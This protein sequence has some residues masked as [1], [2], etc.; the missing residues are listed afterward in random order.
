MVSGGSRFLGRAGAQVSSSGENE[1]WRPYKVPNILVP[2]R[3]FAN[4]DKEQLELAV[5]ELAMKGE[6]VPP[7]G[8]EQADIMNMSEFQLRD[9]LRQAGDEVSRA[10]L[11]QDQ[12]SKNWF[13]GVLS[14][15]GGAIAGP[16]MKVLDPIAAFGEIGASAVMGTVQGFIPGEQEYE[17]LR[18][19][20]MEARGLNGSLLDWITDPLDSIAAQREAW[21]EMEAPW[22]TKFAMEVIFDPLNLVPFKWITAPLKIGARGAKF[23]ARGMRPVEMSIARQQGMKHASQIADKQFKGTKS[24]D[25]LDG[26]VRR[27]RD[28]AAAR[29]QLL[30]P[31]I[32]IGDRTKRGN[33]LEQAK[34]LELSISEIRKEM[35]DRPFG[36][37]SFRYAANEIRAGRMPNPPT[38]WKPGFFD[39]GKEP[40]WRVPKS[41]AEM[42]ARKIPVYGPKRG[43]PGPGEVAG[44]GGAVPFSPGQLST[45]PLPPVAGG[46]VGEEGAAHRVIK[47]D[48]I[49][50]RIDPASEEGRLL[51]DVSRPAGEEGIALIDQET[52]AFVHV[53]AGR[54]IAEVAE[55]RGINPEDLELAPWQPVASNDPANAAIVE[56]LVSEH[57]AEL[58][59]IFGGAKNK[60]VNWMPSDVNY[61]RSMEEYMEAANGAP[62]GPAVLGGDGKA[63]WEDDPNVPGGRRIKRERAQ[64]QIDRIK[65]DASTE[66]AYPQHWEP[67]DVVTTFQN[68]EDPADKIGFLWYY[69]TGMR[70]IEL[71]RIEKA[72]L[73]ELSGQDPSINLIE[74]NAL[75]EEVAPGLEGSTE[76]S[77][78]YHP[79][80]RLSS[81][82][83]DVPI[84]IGTNR[85][86][87]PDARDFLEAYIEG[88]EWNLKIGTT[89]DGQSLTLGLAEDGSMYRDTLLRFHQPNADINMVD[90]IFLSYSGSKKTGKYIPFNVKVDNTRNVRIS[91]QLNRLSERIG[92][93][94][95]EGVKFTANS[96]RHHF[97]T[98]LYVGSQFG[99]G[100][101]GALED[102]I[103]DLMG[104]IGTSNLNE[105]F[106]LGEIILRD[107]LRKSEP[108]NAL[109]NLQ[110]NNQFI[111]DFIKVVDSMPGGDEGTAA[112]R[113]KDQASKALELWQKLRRTML[114]SGDSTFVREPGPGGVVSQDA[115]PYQVA[116][117]SD[118][119]RLAAAENPGAAGVRNGV[120]TKVLREGADSPHA[121]LHPDFSKKA[122]LDLHLWYDHMNRYEGTML[123]VLHSQ[124]D[125]AQPIVDGVKPTPVADFLA[126]E[127]ASWTPE[128]KALYT[129]YHNALQGMRTVRSFMG[130]ANTLQVEAKAG[131]KMFQQHPGLWKEIQANDPNTSV[132]ALLNAKNLGVSLRDHIRN[133]ATDYNR[134]GRAVEGDEAATEA[135]QLP[136]ELRLLHE[137]VRNEVSSL[138]AT[139]SK[140]QDRRTPYGKSEDF[141][142]AAA[143]YFR[144]V[145]AK[146]LIT[147]DFRRT[148]Q[149]GYERGRVNYELGFQPREGESWGG[150]VGKGRGAMHMEPHLVWEVGGDRVEWMVTDITW[151]D[152]AGKWLYRFNRVSTKKA[153][154]TE[155]WQGYAQEYHLMGLRNRQ[156]IDKNLMLKY[157]DELQGWNSLGAVPDYRVVPPKKPGVQPWDVNKTAKALMTSPNIVEGSKA[158][159]DTVFKKPTGDTEKQLQSARGRLT[160]KLQKLL[161]KP[162]KD[163]KLTQAHLFK[164]LSDPMS[165]KPVLVNDPKDP[166]GGS[167]VFSDDVKDLVIRLRRARGGAVGGGDGGRG[168]RRGGGGGIDADNPQPMGMDEWDK[169]EYYHD[170]D[171][172]DFANQPRNVADHSTDMRD[173]TYRKWMQA[174]HKRVFG[175]KIG[176]FTQMPTDWIF[177][178][179]M[180]R[181]WIKKLIGGHASARDAARFRGAQVLGRM[182]YGGDL[183]GYSSKYGRMMNVKLTGAIPPH[184]R[185]LFKEEGIDEYGRGFTIPRP[186]VGILSRGAPKEL[187]G[188]ADWEWE[189]RRVTTMLEMPR[190]EL[191]KYYE[192]T[193]EQLRFYDSYH[194][195]VLNLQHMAKTAGYDIGLYLARDAADLS[196][197]GPDDPRYVPHLQDLGSEINKDTGLPTVPILGSKPKF[198]ETRAFKTMLH[199]ELQ[200]KLVYTQ[201]PVEALKQLFEGVYGFVA[202]RQFFDAVEAS[203]RG[204]DTREFSQ[205]V[206]LG[207]GLLDALRAGTFVPSKLAGEGI[208]RT[209]ESLGGNAYDSFFPGLREAVD[210][211]SK[212]G[213]TDEAKDR[214]RLDIE[215]ATSRYFEEGRAKDDLTHWRAFR[216][217]I[218]TNEEIA[219]LAFQQDEAR[220]LKT[221]VANMSEAAALKGPMKGLSIWSSYV[222]TLS[223]TFDLGSPLIHGFPLLTM[224]PI[225]AI[226]KAIKTRDPFD[227]IRWHETPWAVGVRHMFGSL[228]DPAVRD[229]YRSANNNIMKEMKEHGVAFFG[230]EL[231][232]VTGAAIRQLGDM[233]GIG[234]VSK[235][236][237]VTFNTFLDVAR[238]EYY[239]GMRPLLRMEA[240]GITPLASDLGEL[241]AAVN[242]V[243]GGLDPVRAGI[244]NHQRAVE[245]TY[246]MFAPMLR[247]ATA[248]LIFKAA[249]GAALAPL[250]VAGK[251]RL[252]LERQQALTAIGSI[253]AC[254]GAVGYMIYAS[255]NNKKVFDTDSAD[256]MSAKIGES[257]IGI[258]TPFY[259]LS[260]MGSGIIKQMKDDPNGLYKFSIEDHAVLKMARS[261]TSPSTGSVIDL[262]HGRNFIGDPLRDTD[263]SWEKLKIIRYLARQGMPFWAETYAY[264]FT[265]FN[266]LSSIGEFAGLRASPLPK[267]RQ[268]KQL[269]EIYLMGDD[270]DADL[271]HWR[272]SQM[273][274]GLPITVAEAPALVMDGISAR[275]EDIRELEEAMQ[276]SRLARGDTEVHR[277]NSYMEALDTNR[278]AADKSMAGFSNDFEAGLMSGKTFRQKITEASAELRGAQES[279]SEV[280]KD[281]IEKLDTGRIG[282]MEVTT[283]YLG[284]FFYDIYRAKVT[285]HPTLE[286]EFGNFRP[287][288]FR[289]LEASY[290]LEVGDEYLWDYI[291]RRK[292]RNRDFSPTVRDLYKARETLKPYWTLY[293][294]IWKRGSW[295]AELVAS[296]MSLPTYASKERFKESYP[297]LRPLLSKYERARRRYR[298]ENPDADAALVRFYDYIPVD[299]SR[300][301]KKSSL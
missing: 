55:F 19:E 72:S 49:Q 236:F 281:V 200:G 218:P 13:M 12:S 170:P 67:Q 290:R 149:A 219:K 64:W 257:R 101:E 79:P 191:A 171:L 150:L 84:N 240:D 195:L 246:V 100:K 154:M 286:D 132:R 205:K 296:Y 74:R 29:P 86:I 18:R 26:E 27:L 275:H 148:S 287:E 179:N 114:A 23:A 77:P 252:G 145:E 264:D 66:Y 201:D 265:G 38:N 266:K 300:V 60:G 214:L 45:Y 143:S 289:Q 209:D 177:G 297:K 245:S 5:D 62:E 242:K 273:S 204:V 112:Y 238:V 15:V 194:L 216:N 169:N 83:N 42:Q 113:A 117:W 301:S 81:L 9:I 95:P 1:G 41:V 279:L 198:F 212:G 30:D 271:V 11:E 167:L 199:G 93:A 105:Y 24:L 277:M 130:T 259:A 254:M 78:F 294:D 168:R 193:P 175:A 253:M 50:V 17:R 3:D 282:R 46:A 109:G 146:P 165:G 31:R 269:Q 276:T 183:L 35:A 137:K 298:E 123:R 22:G 156:Q 33:L 213:L 106:N 25:D 147:A 102:W 283:G 122:Y 140:G 91:Y 47:K 230:S 272:N 223:T 280:F 68:L 260:R 128:A 90:N 196:K 187:R 96:L 247:R 159:I 262:I 241:A 249:E 180:G 61:E 21:H 120:I 295:Q 192:L 8:F 207:E 162:G 237:E 107:R 206:K 98:Q 121:R 285:D 174:G 110:L 139:W 152:Q 190:N 51:M 16:A 288:I 299:M 115:S 135:L 141:A 186:G 103:A 184:V 99:F 182:Q 134:L 125:E 197:F 228:R 126:N 119:Q 111:D 20:K 131:R 2:V 56:K 39:K 136:T 34:K 88:K 163:G 235:R 157:E 82:G 158:W 202:D 48:E 129:E 116:D 37:M 255:G 203:G 70:K 118:M 278:K 65:L 52:G 14:S 94:S 164:L 4:L 188:L 189:T 220:E 274:K 261:M 263:G 227:A 208:R 211:A 138:E 40:I 268:L 243:T 124:A 153:I 234:K 233:P 85:K 221:Y 108:T 270:D 28:E 54:T 75:R 127:G 43:E 293:E 71:A 87:T 92:L 250:A 232:E 210:N 291:Q 151:D 104:H 225:H 172:V 142:A 244:S 181:S 69:L 161:G 215:D 224:V 89:A 6:F 155:A 251:A 36:E 160:T 57:Q 176:R 44:A 63:L 217:L 166:T 80:K 144:E 258:G 133:L 53:S 292:K 73:E 222:R 7:S 231:R 178:E 229:R 226:Q 185:A 248:A 58:D 76:K 239:K 59:T 10:P 97:A 173:T 256:F 267:S 32:L 284:D